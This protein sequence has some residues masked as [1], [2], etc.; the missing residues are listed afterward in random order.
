MSHLPSS[1]IRQLAAG[2]FIAALSISFAQAQESAPLDAPAAASAGEGAP[3]SSSASPP[4][5]TLEPLPASA[6]S[7]PEAAAPGD[8]VVVDNPYGLQALWQGSDFVA[9]GTLIILL[10]M[11]F[12]SWLI[13][14]TKLYE[15]QKLIRQGKQTN[16]KFW[17]AGEVEEALQ[18]LP[19][20][21]AYRFIAQ[22]GAEAT[23]K[24][25]GLVGYIGLN[26]WIQ[27]SIHR[28]IESI[29]SN[30]QKGLAFLATVGSTAPFIGLFG[31]V[32][33]I[34]HALTAIGIAGQASIDKVAGPVGESLIM[35]AIGLAV[36]VPAVLGYNW[37]VRRN[38]TLVEEIRSFGA[39]L[40]AVLLGA[41]AERSTTRGP[42]VVQA[43]RAISI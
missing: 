33:G 15:Q 42:Q 24:H 38:K 9:R 27:L 39:E 17:E 5:A 40:H 28:A 14:F 13:I 29:Q 19:K 35:T 11:S 12:G 26:D 30:L 2:A 34:Y 8:T 1:F 31:T 10:I 16:D 32:W 23:S 25:R 21:S 20:E 18:S 6:A 4:S 37:L 7:V 43:I 41:Q 3:E 22:V 36:A